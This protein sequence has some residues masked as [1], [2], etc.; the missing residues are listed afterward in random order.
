MLEYFWYGVGALAVA[1]IL[2]KFGTKAALAAAAGLFGLKVLRDQREAGRAEQ[3]A[4][5]SEQVEAMRDDWDETNREDIDS[6]RAYDYLDG[7]SN[8]KRD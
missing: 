8:D 7:L 4:E 3:R 5:Q 1:V 2:W 6:D